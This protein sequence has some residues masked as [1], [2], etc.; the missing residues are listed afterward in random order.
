MGK[1]RGEQTRIHEF[2]IRIKT[3]IWRGGG[4]AWGKQKCRL[5][6]ESKNC[7]VLD[8]ISPRGSALFA[9]DEKTISKDPQK[10]GR[11]RK[12]HCWWSNRW[13]NSRSLGRRTS[14]RDNWWAF[15]HVSRRISELGQKE[16]KK[17]DL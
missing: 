11:K 7:L 6:A 1:G 9:P 2:G 13:G 16:L 17:I 3:R 4:A 14:G 15:R 8:I 12:S 10:N 5:K